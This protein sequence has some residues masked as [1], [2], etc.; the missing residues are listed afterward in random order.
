MKGIKSLIRVTKFI[1]KI[2]AV[3]AIMP[4]IIKATG[5]GRKEKRYRKI[6]GKSSSI[7]SP[8]C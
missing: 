6:P 4:N 2:N 3:K 7:K 5:D 8:T 1:T